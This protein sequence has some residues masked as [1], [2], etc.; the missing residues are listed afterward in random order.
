MRRIILASESPRRRNLMKQILGNDFEVI[1]SSY[2]EDNCLGMKPKELAMHHSQQKARDVAR[3]QKKGIVIGADTF[4]VFKDS[5]LGKPKDSEDARRML[6]LISGKEVLVITGLTVID[7]ENKK[8]ITETEKTN[9]LMKKMS[10]KEI[11]DYIA[12]GEPLGK[13]GAFAMQERGA[14][15]VER[16]DGCYFNVVGLPI[17]RLNNIL[18]RMGVSIF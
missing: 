16:I 10:K 13:A 11:D 9:V 7:I 15:L 1:P 18:K 2:E 14:V 3:K 8:E 12:T 4:V 6:G 17:F 5:I